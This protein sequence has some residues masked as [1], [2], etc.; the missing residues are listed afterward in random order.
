MQ[1]RQGGGKVIYDHVLSAGD[2]W[3]V[4]ADAGAVTLTTGNAGGLTLV[5]DGVTSPVL[6]RNG[7]VRRNIT[8][9]AASIRDGSI[10]AP[11]AAGDTGSGIHPRQSEPTP[12]AD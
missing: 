8:L 9:D 10:A 4:P 3:V 2:S 7:A 1:V 12:P 11:P 5:A 6:G